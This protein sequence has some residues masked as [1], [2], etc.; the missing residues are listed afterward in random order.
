[1]DLSQIFSQGNPVLI[2]V[3]II[4]VAMSFVSWYIIFWKGMT[5]RREN[6]AY[7]NFNNQNSNIK[8]WPARKSFENTQGS[9]NFLIE[10]VKKLETILP[11]YET[12]EAKAEILTMHLSQVLDDLRSRLDKG[13]TI[14]ASIGSSAPFIGLFGT[15]WGIYNAL[16]NIAAQGNAGL[17]VVAG[18]IAEAL[19]A[20]AVGLFAAIPAVLA[21]NTFVRLNRLL[22]QNL[23]H[24]AE[25]M[26]VYLSNES[27]RS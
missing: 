20:T 17:S 4:L 11:Q 9:I 14:L 7:L 26:T 22:V 27:K 12:H 6:Q 13:L 1:M 15:V 19:V 25:Q 3:F 24:I 23:R 18:P 10:E 21:Y 2:A 8:N 16:Q 5:I